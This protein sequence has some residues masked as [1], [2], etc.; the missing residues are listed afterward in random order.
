ML[1]MRRDYRA[2]GVGVQTWELKRDREAGGLS[3]QAKLF[4]PDNSEF[5]DESDPDGSKG[6]RA[7]REN[8]EPKSSNKKPFWPGEVEKKVLAGWGGKGTRP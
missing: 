1:E 6:M 4:L 2:E 5:A 7:W 8:H 3:N